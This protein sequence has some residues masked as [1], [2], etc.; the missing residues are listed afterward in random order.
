MSGRD[1]WES[2]YGAAT[3]DGLRPPSRFV[4]EVL[5]LLPPGRAL[6]LACGDGRHALYLARHGWRAEA[7]DFAHAG[8][9]RLLTI[10]RRE[11]LLVDALQADLEQFPLPRARYD[12]VVNTRYLQRSLFGALKDSLRPGGA[13]V[14]ET[15][16]RDQQQL[17]HPRNPAFLL[18]R[19]ELAERFSDCDIIRYEEGRF[20]TE[21][22]AA[23]LA[24]LLARRGEASVD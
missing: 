23:F 3:D 18:E 8:L 21:S 15:F 7:V 12:V 1:E 9:V 24:R 5:P 20:E 2:R 17:G 13:I 10:A 22:G 16:I 4:A 6:D 19:G 14:F 11:G